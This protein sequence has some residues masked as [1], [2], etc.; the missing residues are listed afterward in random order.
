MEWNGMELIHTY[1]SGLNQ[2]EQRRIRS[3]CLPPNLDSIIQSF[4]IHIYTTYTLYTLYILY[5][6]I[7]CRLSTE[8]KTED[9]NCPEIVPPA[10][11]R[12]PP[13]TLA[14]RCGWRKCAETFFPHQGLFSEESVS[15][16][17][18]L[19]LCFSSLFKKK[20]MT[21]L[22]HLF[23]GFLS[24]MRLFYLFIYIYTGGREK[25]MK[26]VLYLIQCYVYIYIHIYIREWLFVF[27]S[28]LSFLLGLYF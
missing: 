6:R 8:Q 2:E 15:R 19:S 10:S 9:G 5:I 11:A 12:L 3:V 4:N 16:G 28:F 26:E 24:S 22:S 13:P 1:T 25:V 18:S 14:G 17:F 27:L 23:F 20:Q 7:E 21:F